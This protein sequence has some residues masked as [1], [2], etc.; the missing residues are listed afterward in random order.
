MPRR[1]VK[2]FSSDGDRHVFDVDRKQAIDMIGRG[3]AEK[4]SENPLSL[5]LVQPAN[6]AKERRGTIQ[7]LRPG[8][9]CQIKIKPRGN[10]GSGRGTLLRG[11]RGDAFESALISRASGC[12]NSETVV[13]IEAWGTSMSGIMMK[14]Q[15]ARL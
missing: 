12:A 15:R 3:V 2:L 6:S 1:N 13:A 9:A 11:G 8:K 5:R 14:P 4:R 10:K 7:S